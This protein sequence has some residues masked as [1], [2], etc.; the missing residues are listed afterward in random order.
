[1]WT[2]S[3]QLLAVCACLQAKHVVI[4]S[5]YQ[6]P[7][8]VAAMADLIQAEIIKFAEPGEVEVFFSAH[9]VP[10]S[11]V[12]DGEAG[13]ELEVAGVCWAG[14][15]GRTRLARGPGGAS[16]GLL[17]WVGGVGRRGYCTS[18]SNNPNKSWFSIAPPFFSLLAARRPVQGG[19]GALCVAD[20]GGVAA[21][22]RAQPPHAGLPEP[23][24]AGG[25]AQALHG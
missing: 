13:A 21:A 8:Y 25:V 11:Y 23:R 9:G 17:A 2:S 7:G 15:A 10:Q 3:Q 18:E 16:G 12:D 1:M 22:R 24:G 14:W 4:P 5:W 20:H 6:R 19:D